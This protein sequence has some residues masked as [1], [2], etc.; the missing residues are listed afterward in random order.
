M[1]LSKSSTGWGLSF[2]VVVLFILQGCATLNKDECRSA[3]WHNIGY[4]DAY[5]GQPP[6]RI[7]AHRKACA[8]YG[9]QPNVKLYQQGWDEGIVK[10]CSPYRGY[11]LGIEATRIKVQCPVDQRADFKQAYQYGL[12]I[13][14]VVRKIRIINKAITSK[15]KLL[16]TTNTQLVQTEE[17]LI[18][19]SSEMSGQAKGLLRLN[20]LTHREIE[21]ESAI[22]SFDEDRKLK[23]KGSKSKRSDHDSQGK[24]ARKQR[25]DLEHELKIIRKN[26]RVLI[27]ELGKIPSDRDRR[28]KL[29]DDTK[30]LAQEANSIQR[31]LRR[32]GKSRTKL[33]EQMRRLKRD[34]PY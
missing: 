24:N 21:I 5:F 2:V 8:E 1:Q 19:G 11:S 7:R 17:K 20:Q 31:D 16:N 27:P 13:N 10:F 14:R 26:I 18:N 3:D 25:A 4:E 12:R 15:E 32:M 30:R 28:R 29:L 33:A 23:G 9:V 34:A 6:S 22:L